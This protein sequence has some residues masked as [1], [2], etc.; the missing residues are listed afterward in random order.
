MITNQAKE[1]IQSQK[2]Q[3]RQIVKDSEFGLTSQWV[4][5]HSGNNVRTKWQVGRDYAVVPKRGMPQVYYRFNGDELELA[6]IDTEVSTFP[7]QT[8]LDYARQ[9]Y[10][11]DWKSVLQFH[12]WKPL[13]IR[14]TDIRCEPLQG[15]TE[16]DAI[17][18]GIKTKHH[19]IA[20]LYWDYITSEWIPTPAIDSYR[21]LWDSINKR[22]G[23]RWQDNPDIW[24]LEFEVVQS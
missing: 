16:A 24:V 9:R 18:E 21:T 14:L 13:S 10:E 20:P 2:T 6:H 11:K 4:K 7:N 5:Y 19:S 15:I 3:Y 12:D 17:A 23:T 8:W 22:A 1:I